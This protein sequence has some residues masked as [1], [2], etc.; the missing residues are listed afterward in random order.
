MG[1][2]VRTFRILLCW[3]LILMLP[4][5]VIAA[6][7]PVALLHAQRG[8]WVNGKEVPDSTAIFAGDTLQTQA[9]AVASLDSE[10]STILLKPESVATLQHNYLTLDHG[11]VSVSTATQYRVKVRC[12]SVVPVVQDW[13]QYDVTDVS[14]KLDVAARKKD[15]NVDHGAARAKSSQPDVSNPETSSQATVREG[16]EK[17]HDESEACGAAERPGGADSTLNAKWIYAG[18]GGTGAI[19]LLLLLGGG[20]GKKPSISPSSP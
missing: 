19:I 12:L 14:G 8:V 7:L 6:D 9:G 1:R 11:G 10:G 16:E 15:V 18:A 3:C 17:S 5:S 20:G 13:T 2:V 4:H